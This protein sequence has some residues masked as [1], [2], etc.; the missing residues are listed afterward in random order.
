MTGKQGVHM[1]AKGKATK[2]KIDAYITANPDALKRDVCKV[3]NIG[4][5]TLRKHLRGNDNVK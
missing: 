5:V 2:A 1:T 3:L 4:Y